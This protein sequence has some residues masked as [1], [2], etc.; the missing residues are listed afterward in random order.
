V[1][2]ENT[3]TNVVPGDFNHDGRLDLLVMYES[4]EGWWPSKKESTG[5]QV[6]FGRPDGGIGEKRYHCSTLSSVEPE[7]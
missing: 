7:D 1:R 2:A 6:F 5:M 4:D 3:V